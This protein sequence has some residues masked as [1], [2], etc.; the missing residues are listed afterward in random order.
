M[1]GRPTRNYEANVQ[2]T[3]R[4]CQNSEANNR[5]ADFADTVR[6]VSGRLR[7]NC[8]ANAQ[9]TSPELLGEFPDYFTETVMRIFGAASG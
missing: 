4:L 7:R 6:R 8:D 3:V 9:S 5:S 1:S 2:S